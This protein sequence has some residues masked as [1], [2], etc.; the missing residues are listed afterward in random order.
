MSGHIVKRGRGY[1]IVLELGKDAAGKR[2]TRWISGFRTK[3]QAQAKLADLQ[4]EIRNGS[5]IEPARLTTGQWLDEWI[6]KWCGH[7]KPYTRRGREFIVSQMKAEIGDIPLQKLSG[8]DVQQMINRYSEVGTN[9]NRGPLSPSTIGKHMTCLSAAL[10]KAVELELLRRNPVT[11]TVRPRIERPDLQILDQDESKHLLNV[12]RETPLYMPVLL[13]LTT[14]MRRGEILALRWS[15]V[16]L[17]AQTLS[18]RRNAVQLDK[19]KVI[20]NET[21]T[22]KSRP[23]TL[24]AFVIAE[25]RRHNIAQKEMRLQVGNRWQ[26][27]NLVCCDE[28]GK[29]LKPEW[30]SSRFSYFAKTHGLNIT[31]HGLRH[32]HASLLLA[33]GVHMKVVQERLGHSKLAM[34]MD[35]YSHLAKGMQEEAASKLECLG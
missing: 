22:G 30:L 4:Y 25:L 3:K 1:T 31:F 15:D 9:A 5:Y 10:N 11:A 29:A 14:G 19:G 6:E 33:Q 16:D 34:T 28:T 24:P 35:T 17:E 23:I 26:D 20:F 32:S 27:N 8:R 18:V 13:G 2:R 21:K 7:L 12:L